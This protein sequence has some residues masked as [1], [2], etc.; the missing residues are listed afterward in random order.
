MSGV[1]IIDDIS[2]MKKKITYAQSGVD[3]A[4]GDRAVDLVKKN[5][6]K[7]FGYF[8]GKVLTKIG[9]F[10]G[11]AELE[12]GRIVASSTDGVGTKLIVACLMNRHATVGIDLVA[13]SVNDIA[14]LG[15]KPAIFLDYIAMGKQIPERTEKIMAGIIRG[16]HE[17]QVALLG[18]EMAEMPDMYSQE[19]YDLAG[20]AVGFC[21]SKKD[22]ILGKRIKP[23]MKVYGFPS[24]G[25]HSNG[26]SLVRKVFGIDFKNPKKAK[27]VLHS[28]IPGLSMT[29]GEELLIP[30][31]IYV[32]TIQ[33]LIASYEI[34]GLVHIT[35]GGLVENPPRV[36]P[37]G[38]AMKLRKDSW[39]R[40]RIFDA[41]QKAG[42]IS[43]YEM[44]RTFNCGI[45][46]IVV[47]P[48]VI[49]EGMLIGE[50]VKGGKEVIFE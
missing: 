14:V 2:R 7:T 21:D 40:Q 41:I 16:C 15:I 33:K 48:D 12:D 32:K 18:G 8:P 11:V 45:G 3:I 47:S 19:E 31:K 28:K 1:K 13:M 17:A 10:G 9:S 29:L 42:N 30:T 20:F 5:I 37:S 50:I 49:K 36:L 34:A 44:L 26:Y 38:C 27:K 6:H 4:A 24:S 35:G 46:L 25:L 43:E 22:L 39:K 23:G